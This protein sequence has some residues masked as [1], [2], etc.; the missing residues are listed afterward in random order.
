[1]AG[2]P[3]L[4]EQDPG[5]HHRE[6]LTTDG[7]DPQ[8]VRRST[9]YAGE[10]LPDGDLQNLGRRDAEP[11]AAARED[12]MPGPGGHP[13]AHRKMNSTRRFAFHASSLEAGLSGWASP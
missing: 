5:I 13:F 11:A 4:T 3:G 9:R 1:M 6:H 10:G 12:E 2:L 7:K 8:H